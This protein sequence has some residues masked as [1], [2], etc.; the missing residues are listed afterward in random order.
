MQSPPPP[1]SPV[2]PPQ[3]PAPRRGGLGCA[4]KGC[5]VLLVVGLLFGAAVGGAGYLA[6]SRVRGDYTADHPV[7]VP[8]S[9]ATEAQAAEVAARLKAFADTVNGG[10]RATLTL[11]AADLNAV[12]ARDPRYRNLRGRVF[13]AVVKDTLHARVS[14]PLDGI[15]TFR[16]RWFNG[17]AGLDVAFEDGEL[18]LNPVSLEV[19]GKPVSRQV[20][21]ALSTPEVRQQLNDALRDKMRKDPK[22]QET[23]RKV[24]SIRFKGDKLVIV[25]NGGSGDDAEDEGEGDQK[26]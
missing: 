7:P 3:G 21:R 18:T 24:E 14:A 19:A 25:A 8:V 15:P 2:Y 23:M 16:G 17:E 10:G 4:A 9:E 5:L 13:F 12:V 6:W 22:F 20:L 11:S 1:L 26:T